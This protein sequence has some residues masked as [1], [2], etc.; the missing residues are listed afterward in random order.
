MSAESREPQQIS[1]EIWGSLGPE[2]GHWPEGDEFP[3]ELLYEGVE[4]D[5]EALSSLPRWRN[6]SGQFLD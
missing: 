3:E 1:D 4:P 6:P 5:W 2:E